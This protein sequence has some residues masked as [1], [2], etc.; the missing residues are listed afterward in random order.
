[1]HILSP[2]PPRY[3]L[4]ALES[5]GEVVRGVLGSRPRLVETRPHLRGFTL[6]LRTRVL[7]VSMIHWHPESLAHLLWA[8]PCMGSPTEI[9][10][11]EGRRRE[12]P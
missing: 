1:M 5:Q 12:R 6:E 3:R 9:L 4:R 2:L 10:R 11:S 7:V 8:G